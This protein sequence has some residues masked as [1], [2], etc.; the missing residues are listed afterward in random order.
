M[1]HLDFL[2]L[3]FSESEARCPSLF[4]SAPGGYLANWN[5]SCFIQTSH[6]NF[7]WHK[8]RQ[9][10]ANRWKWDV[11]TRR[12]EG[13][14]QRGVL[15]VL[16]PSLF[17]ETLFLFKGN[18]PSFV[19]TRR[20]KKSKSPHGYTTKLVSQFF[21]SWLQSLVVGEARK[22]YSSGFYWRDACEPI[23]LW[24]K[25][26]AISFPL[27]DAL[28]QWYT[29]WLYINSFSHISDNCPGCWISSQH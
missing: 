24:G 12:T 5:W 20:G 26:T 13:L 8:M 9:R 11:A 27:P 10:L 28:F 22:M 18:L 25:E 2:P 6:G 7:G 19:A 3:T 21:G 15:H 14:V 17:L 29:V 4:L 1:P 23:S 16:V